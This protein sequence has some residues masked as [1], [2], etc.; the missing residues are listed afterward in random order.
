MHHTFRHRDQHLTLE[1]HRTGNGRF[2]V[3][4][5]GQPHDVEAALLDPSTLYLVVGGRARTARIARVGQTYHVGLD[6][7]VYVLTPEAGGATAGGPGALASP[8][9]VAPMPGKV[10]QVLAREGQ[11]VAAGDGLLILEAMK[12]ENRIVAEAA[13]V[14]RKIH[15]SEGQMVDGGALLLELEYLDS[16]K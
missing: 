11:Q 13:A 9:V 7:D 3:A 6:G 12:M 1:L 14:V 10:L 5:N 15:V 2:Q 16:R 4:V 8:Q